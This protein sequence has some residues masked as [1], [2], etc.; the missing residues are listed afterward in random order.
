[1]APRRPRFTGSVYK[2]GSVYQI[3][4]FVR[5]QRVRESTKC[6]SKEEAQKILNTRLLAARAGDL[7]I[8]ETTFKALADLYIAANKPRWKESTHR[9]VKIIVEQHLNIFDARNPASILPGELDTFVAKK[10]EEGL[11]D[12][13]VNRLLVILKAILR[14]GIRNKALRELPEFPERF[15]ERPYVRTGHI[16]GWDFIVLCDE[17][18]ED[19][20]PWLL[21]MVTAAFTFGF[22]KGELLHMRC[23]QIDLERHTITLPGGSTKNKM[24]RR[25]VLNP[26]GKLSKLLAKAIKGKD[27]QAY[28]FSRDSQGSIPVRDFRVAWDRIVTAAKIKTGSGPDGHL[29]FHDLR[30]SAISRMSSAGLSE[31]ERM[32]IAGHLSV[33]VHRRY[34]QI[35]EYTAR[36]IAEKIDIE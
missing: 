19:R 35:S 29:Q 34:N 27:P 2:R 9:W 21:A 31:E 18:D 26:K 10:K 17:I 24:P 15:D 30:R 20:E 16:D 32:A 3:Q 23:N 22:R 5:G 36:Q 14:Y 25:I 12:C 1:M 33:E 11:S 8:K 6:Y 7:P 13:R 4:Y 28:V